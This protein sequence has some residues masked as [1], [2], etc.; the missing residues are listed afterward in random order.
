MH[1]IWSYHGNRPT[2]PPP[3]TQT[4]PPTNRQD[5]LQY[6]VP[7]LAHSVTTIAAAAKTITKIKIIIIIFPRKEKNY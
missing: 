6:T 4:H 1:A 7:Q 5:R 3:H 2:Y